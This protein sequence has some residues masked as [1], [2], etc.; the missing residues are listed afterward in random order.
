VDSKWLITHSIYKIKIVGK[1]NIPAEG[2]ALLVSNHISYIDGFLVQFSLSR[3]VRFVVY[4]KLYRN[5]ILKI[6][7]NL[8]KAIPI[9]SDDSPKEIIKSFKKVKEELQKGGL[10]CIFAEGQLSRTGNMLPFNKGFEY[11]VKGTTCPIIPVHLDRVWG[12]IFSFKNNKFFFKIPKRRPYPVTV[13]FGK[14]MSS[15]SKAFAVRQTV[16]ELGSEAFKYRVED[17]IPLPLAFWREAK[18]HPFKFCMADSTGKKLSYG[19][20]LYVSLS[21]SKIIKKHMPPQE[22]VGIL[23]PSSVAAVLSNISVSLTEVIP[24]NINFTLSPEVMKKIVDECNINYIITSRKFLEKRNISQFKNMLFI[25]DLIKEM[26]IIT[27]V[28]SII[29][30]WLIPV[31]MYA[32]FKLKKTL[33]DSMQNVATIIFSSGSTGV[34]KGIMLTHANITINVEGFYQ[35]FNIEKNDKV[36]GI[37]PFFHSFGFTATLWFP[38]LSGAGGCLSL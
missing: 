34:P 7:F 24:V 5:P 36:L 14:P 25:E 23:L 20:A 12:S 18:K 10:I 3:P 19:K 22:M 21:L 38:L 6:L 35:I 27:L 32:R 26:S 9:S 11:M 30:A 4:K 13:S 33:S 16:L 37:L 8:S 2:S 28:A 15:D 31:K 29:K 1:D 17:H